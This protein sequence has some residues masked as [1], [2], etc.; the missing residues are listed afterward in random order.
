MK[1]VA[2]RTWHLLAG[3]LLMCLVAS[4]TLLAC[5]NGPRPNDSPAPEP[6][7]MS[8]HS[9][10]DP[11]G[12]FIKAVEKVDGTPF[13]AVTIHNGEVEND[14]YLECTFDDRKRGRTD[15]E[16]YDFSR[17]DRNTEKSEPFRI[18][19]NSDQLFEFLPAAPLPVLTVGAS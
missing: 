6:K 1:R 19:K 10:Q 17:I 11:P 12:A 7:A 13:V 2:T 9:S 8:A 15:T 3:S 18:D 14:L 5:D 4:A 16:R